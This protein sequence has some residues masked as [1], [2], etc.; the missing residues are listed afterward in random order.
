MLLVICGMI[1]VIAT[2]PQLLK[3]IKL[4]HSTEF[5]LFSWIVWLIYQTVSVAYSWRIKAYLYVVIN[6]LWVG[7]Y[8]VMVILIIRYRKNDS[9]PTKDF[10]RH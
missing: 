6:S 2:I 5:N 8:L 7:F 10:S 1:S 9:E 4:K 3:L